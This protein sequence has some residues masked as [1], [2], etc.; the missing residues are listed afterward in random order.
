MGQMEIRR[1]RYRPNGKK[2]RR[3]RERKPL[4]YYKRYGRRYAFIADKDWLL[5]TYRK[6]TFRRFVDKKRKKKLNKKKSL[7][8]RASRQRRKLLKNKKFFSINPSTSLKK[9]IFVFK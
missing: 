2:Y 4:L 6:R 9:K 8:F 3:R 7:N 5:Y 1:P